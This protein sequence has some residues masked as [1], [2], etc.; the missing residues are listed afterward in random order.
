MNHYGYFHGPYGLSLPTMKMGKRLAVRKVTPRTVITGKTKVDPSMIS[1]FLRDTESN[2]AMNTEARKS[3]SYPYF[4]GKAQELYTYSLE[5]N[6]ELA[7]VELS[8]SPLLSAW[9]AQL[10]ES[11]AQLQSFEEEVEELG[12]GAG[13]E[14]LNWILEFAG[15][16]SLGKLLSPKRAV[17]EALSSTRTAIYE[18]RGKMLTVMGYLSSLD[19]RQRLSQLSTWQTG[20]DLNGMVEN[21]ARSFGTTQREMLQG[22]WDMPPGG[23]YTGPS[24]KAQTEYAWLATGGIKSWQPTCDLYHHRLEP[25]SWAAVERDRIGWHPGYAGYGTTTMSGTHSSPS[26]VYFRQ[27]KPGQP[28]YE[29]YSTALEDQWGITKLEEGCLPSGVCPSAPW[30]SPI[31]QANNLIRIQNVGISLVNPTQLNTML[32]DVSTSLRKAKSKLTSTKSKFERLDRALVG[33]GYLVKPKIRAIVEA[34]GGPRA[35]GTL[36]L[37]VGSLAGPIGA[38]AGALVSEIVVGQLVRTIWNTLSSGPGKS[39]DKTG[40][41]KSAFTTVTQPIVNEAFGWW[42]D[43]TTALW[44]SERKT[45]LTAM[46]SNLLGWVADYDAMETKTKAIYPR[47]SAAQWKRLGVAPSC[48]ARTPDFELDTTGWTP[49]LIGPGGRIGGGS[50][51]GE[52]IPTGFGPPAGTVLTPY[53][54]V[55]HYGG[56]SIGMTDVWTVLTKKKWLLVGVLGAGAFYYHKRKKNES[57]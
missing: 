38:L 31:T 54:S 21:V 29:R 43:N 2:V 23:M 42:K 35:L 51:G 55:K 52:D 53:G 56:N 25:K 39:A 5:L 32:S 34:T 16:S 11:L 22:W 37:T 6:E 1:S 50:S 20:T 36:A 9:G 8:L 33:T 28:G 57:L 30:I 40:T 44:R 41:V 24:D 27:P 47:R 10:S 45:Q 17:D 4:Q 15:P 46:K 26:L 49:E 3:A 48:S 18:V 12:A 13:T 19:E 14:I 7:D